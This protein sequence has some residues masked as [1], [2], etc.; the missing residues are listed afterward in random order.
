MVWNYKHRFEKFHGFLNADKRGQT[1][2][3]LDG[4][5]IVYNLPIYYAWEDYF[6]E[7]YGPATTGYIGDVAADYP[8]KL[9]TTH[10]R[11]RAHSSMAENPLLRELSHNT[12]GLDEHNEAEYK[13]NKKGNDYTYYA[14]APKQAF[15]VKNNPK[16]GDYVMPTLESAE[17]VRGGLYK[18]IT[19]EELIAN[20]DI[21]TFTPLL[22]NPADAKDKNGN[23]IC[24]NGD[25]IE[26]RNPIGVVYCVAKFTERCA[27]G[28]VSLHQG[29]WYDPRLINNEVVDVGGCCNTLM[30][31]QPS[32]LD[33]GNAEHSALV[34][35]KLIKSAK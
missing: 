31:S 26:V 18:S 16:T 14:S 25:L 4:G 28:F 20:K 9:T 22:M 15:P 27:P 2:K 3:D 34:K 8:L 17:V 30:A 10:N 29:A 5:E 12:M 6:K 33:N 32:R 19:P 1:K 11:F 23:T 24:E 35:I 13:R 21:A 7:A